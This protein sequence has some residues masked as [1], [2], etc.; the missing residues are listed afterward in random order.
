VTTLLLGLGLLA[1]LG[2]LLVMGVWIGMALAAT[3]WVAMIAFSN[4]PPGLNLATAVWSSTASWEL[5]ALPLFVWMGEILFRTKLSEQMFSGIAPWVTRIPGRLLH[6]GIVGCGIFGMVSGSSAAT[7]ATISKIALPELR[8]RGYEEGLALGSLAGAGTLGILL[9]PS[10]IMVVY[11]VAADVSIIQM[12]LAGIFPGL[13][14]ML[15]LMG[16]VFVWA[17]F[18]PQRV[19]PSDIRMTFMEKLR[20][21]KELIP[22]ILL[23]VAVIGAIVAGLATATESAAFGVLGSLLIAV[24]TRSLTWRNFCES[25]LGATRL[26]CMIMFILAGAAF[27]TLAMGYTGIPR[28]LAEFV[29]AL[30]PDRYALIA[31]LCA[32]YVVLGTALDGISMIVLTTSIVLPMIDKVGIDL[33]WFGVFIVLLVEISE[34]TPPVGFNLFVLQT[35]SGRDATFVARSAIP[36][37]CMLVLA[38]AIITIFPQIATWLPKVVMA[39]P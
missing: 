18:H 12:F 1:F 31:I 5:A 23:I 7:C 16:Y 9:P 33:I 26:S 10:I 17:L 14:V 8:K 11:A 34:L 30:Q 2:I 3:G 39:R 13:L 15:L 38:I 22:C 27:L 29:V 35:M 25:L 19:P 37:F 28:A 20:N 32:M 6:V 36:F 4:S 21:S 24:S